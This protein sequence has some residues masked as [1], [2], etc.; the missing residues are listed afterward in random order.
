MKCGGCCENV[1]LQMGDY[2]LK[3]HMFAIDMGGCDI[4]LGAEWLCTLGQITMDFKELYMSFVKDSHTHLLQ[5]NPL[6][7][8]SSHRKE[9]L[10]KKGHS[11]IIAEFHA[12]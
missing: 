1:K 3:T 11:G 8:I 6:E 7:V 5:A 9:K 12:I 2:H 4:V 10:L